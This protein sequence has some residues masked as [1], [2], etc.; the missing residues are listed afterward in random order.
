M[1]A[2]LTASRMNRSLL[3]AACLASLAPCAPGTGAAR[4]GRSAADLE[5]A[6]PVYFNVDQGTAGQG[7][8]PRE[9]FPPILVD[10]T[11]WGILPLNYTQGERACILPGCEP[12]TTGAFPLLECSAANGSVTTKLNGGV[13]QRANLSGHLAMIRET[14]PLW[15]PD[16]S[17]SGNAVIDF[18]AW[19][20]IWNEM[21]K[22]A[23]GTAIAF[24][25]PFHQNSP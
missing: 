11:R 2:F 4:L 16:P 15:I 22:H 23:G 18:E 9:P 14:L 7:G 1:E 13:P 5:N 25:G 21:E 10:I 20:T 6:W 17:W 8:T 12:W 19:T 24:C 3:V